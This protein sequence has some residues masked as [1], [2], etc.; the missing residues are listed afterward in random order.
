MSKHRMNYGHRVGKRM[1]HEMCGGGPVKMARGGKVGQPHINARAGIKAAPKLVK[2]V[3][4]SVPKPQPPQGIAAAAM[5]SPA[6]QQK[7]K[8]FAKGGAVKA[9]A[10]QDKKVAAVAVHKHE[11]HMHKGEPLTKLARGGAVK[12][13]IH[14]N[15]ANK[16]KLRAALKTP[17][18]AKIPM[19]KLEAA[20]NSPNPVTRKRANF[21]INAR[22]FSHK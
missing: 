9:D 20:K 11:R 16:G 12:K 19:A 14:I 15:P 13:T 7:L 3:K 1:E 21:A 22:S 18:G 2:A 10:A 6:P 5:P 17:K 8:G 4:S